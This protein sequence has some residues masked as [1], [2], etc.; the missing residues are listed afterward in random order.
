M[1]SHSSLAP[2][3]LT[4][5]INPFTIKRLLPFDSDPL[6]QVTRWS[7]PVGAVSGSWA[8]KQK[9]NGSEGRREI[10]CSPHEKLRSSRCWGISAHFICSIFTD[11]EVLIL[12]SSILLVSIFE[13]IRIFCNL[14]F[15]N[16][17]NRR[18]ASFFVD[19]TCHYGFFFF[20]MILTVLISD[21]TE[22]SVFFLLEIFI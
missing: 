21:W 13:K 12:C 7:G 9:E 1:D 2:Q 16:S 20:L 3:N 11:K 19:F 18:S 4:A 5:N 6:L 14:F 22:R 8:E 10:S 15:P 17:S